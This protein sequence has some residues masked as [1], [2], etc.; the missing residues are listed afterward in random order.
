MSSKG[1]DVYIEYS[2]ELEEFYG[3]LRE[4]L[5]S[6]KGEVRSIAPT[7]EVY[8]F[9][10]VAKGEF[11]AASDV[12]ILVVLESFEEVN[13]YALKARIKSKYRSYPIELHVTDRSTFERWYRRFIKPEELREVRI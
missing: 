1:F 12:D 6:V 9:G 5:L 10:S 13:V 2:R 8:L 11:T 7:A 3:K 4:V